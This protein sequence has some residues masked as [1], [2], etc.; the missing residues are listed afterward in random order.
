MQLQEDRRWLRKQP[1]SVQEMYRYKLLEPDLYQTV[2]KM[3]TERR[4][5]IGNRKDQPMLH[6]GKLQHYYYIEQYPTEKEFRETL[7]EL[8]SRLQTE[9]SFQLLIYQTGVEEY[10]VYARPTRQ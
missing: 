4:E 10:V 3:V 5:V 8:E 6:I 1:P 2:E 9:A 7:R